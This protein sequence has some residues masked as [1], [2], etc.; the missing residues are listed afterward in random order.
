MKIKTKSIII[1]RRPREKKK[2]VLWRPF[3]INCFNINDAHK[4]CEEPK[5]VI[6]FNKIHRIII[7]NLDV[8]YLAAGKDL[9]INNIEYLNIKDDKHGHLSITGKQKKSS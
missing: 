2:D 6:G 1:A 9:V 4:K 5:K 8:S 3:M 7:K